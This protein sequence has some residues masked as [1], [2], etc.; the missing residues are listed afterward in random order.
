VVIRFFVGQRVRLV[1][2][3]NGTG[4]SP[5]GEEARIVGQD[6][7]VGATTGKLFPWLVET[8][9]GQMIACESR[10]MEPIL[11][12]GHELVEI[13]QLLNVLPELEHVFVGVRA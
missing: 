9:K 12:D 13:E 5:K 2:E 1:G 4:Q 11:L 6:R 8:L 3:W 10:D 7:F